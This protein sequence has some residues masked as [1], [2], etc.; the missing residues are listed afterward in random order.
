M[1]ATAQIPVFV[2]YMLSVV[3]VLFEV[4]RVS[5][6]LQTIRIQLLHLDIERIA[7]LIN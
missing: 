3:C 7:V 6:V 4:V 5:E 1:I 2:L